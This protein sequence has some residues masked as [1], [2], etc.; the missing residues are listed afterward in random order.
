ML[1]AMGVVNAVNLD[2]GG[3][4]TAVMN[5]QVTSAPSDSWLDYCYIFLQSIFSLFIQ[6]N[7]LEVVFEV[8]KAQNI[9]ITS[10][11]YQFVCHK[12]YSK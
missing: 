3:S 7:T 9:L 8:V 11:I 10:Y 2:G 5:G 12:F 4:S 1:K 6:R